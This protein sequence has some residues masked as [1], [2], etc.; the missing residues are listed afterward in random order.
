MH[1]AKLPFYFE[2]TLGGGEG[3]RTSQLLPDS[4]LELKTQWLVKTSQVYISVCQ[5][6]TQLASSIAVTPEPTTQKE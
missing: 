1:N 5:V 2:E 6:G 4:I 3:N